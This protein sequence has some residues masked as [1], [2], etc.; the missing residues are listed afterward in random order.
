MAKIT[1]SLSASIKEKVFGVVKAKASSGESP[2]ALLKVISKN[3][4]AMSAMARDM[5]V[6]SQNIKELVKVMGGKPSDTE[7]KVAGSGLTPDERE[8]K[9]AVELEKDKSKEESKKP[10]LVSKLG[11]K[12]LDKFKATKVGKKVTD[13]FAELKKAFNP[14]KIFKALKKYLVIGA[15]IGAVFVAFKDTFVEWAT[16]LFDAIKTKFDE[17][18]ASI[19]QWFQD[20]IQPI[21]DKAKELIKPVI[22]A[23]SG[24]IT[25]IGDWFKEKFEL[26]KGIFENPLNFIK[27]IIDKVFV[28][29]D[30][31]KEKF[32]KFK[33]FIKPYVEEALDTPIIK[34]LPPVLVL[35]ALTGAKSPKEKKE[36]KKK[37]APPP[38][39]PPKAPPPPPPKAPAAPAAPKAPA[40]APKAPAPA[41][42]APAPT[43]RPKAPAAAPKAPAAAPKAPA[44]APKASATAPSP[45]P[46]PGKA[47]KKEKIPGAPTGEP[48]VKKISPEAGKKAMLDEMNKQK[49]SDPTTRAAIMAQAAKETGGF[50]LLSE[51]LRY[52]VSGLK[53]VFKRL[54]NT[55][56]EVLAAAVKGGAGAIGALIYG[57]NKDSPSYK[58]GVKN[59]GN[60]EPGDGA[61]Y[62]GR[63][64]F[65]LTGRANYKRAGALEGPEKLLEM[66]E[67]AKTAVD[68]ALRY[69]G[70]FGD[71][72]AFTKYVNG[73]SVGLKERGE[74]FNA[75]INDPAITKIDASP[76]APSGGGMASS[77]TSVAS[78]QRQQQ[79]SQTP[80]VVNAPTTN[81]QVVKKTQVASSKRLDVGS[82]LANAAA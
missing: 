32:Q 80:V 52:S 42:K 39:P 71:V 12:A 48:L 81:T 58:F 55:S 27:K 65:Q 34:Y 9:L 45:A 16:G 28:L 76:S 2:D 78:G 67:A 19:G 44:A 25:K 43:P 29:F 56:E 74:Y 35:K 82:S 14:A 13:K 15:I 57:G 26:I 4:M 22:D 64:F 20:T 69:K 54:K 63:G 70:D 79:K 73:G 47:D 6:A 40:P 72:K 50:K 66:G 1:E 18:T 38:P 51:D 23:V 41:P 5:N 33:D 60:T 68:F 46:T 61:R 10:S 11:K 77:S 59:L 21:I 17:F 24:F 8:R 62:R 7:D 53:K 37:P 49:V 31:V 36:E 30:E 75:Y 3:F